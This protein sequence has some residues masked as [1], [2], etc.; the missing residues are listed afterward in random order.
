MC[1]PLGFKYVFGFAMRL[2]VSKSFKFK[3]FKGLFGHHCKCTRTDRMCTLS[4]DD[5]NTVLFHI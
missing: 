1:K 2:S 3:V 5:Q 4:D